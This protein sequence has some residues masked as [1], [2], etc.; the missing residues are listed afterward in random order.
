MTFVQPIK[1]DFR[2]TALISLNAEVNYG[3]QTNSLG[4]LPG[5]FS[6]VLLWVA[7]VALPIALV[8]VV[9]FVY[10]TVVEKIPKKDS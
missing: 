8:S 3:V 5:V 10:F 2:T 9:L 1:A 6:E 4:V 7:F